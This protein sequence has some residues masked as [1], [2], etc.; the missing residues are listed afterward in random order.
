MPS[1]EV[2]CGDQGGNGKRVHVPSVLVVA[3]SLYEF[4]KAG[5]SKLLASNN[6]DPVAL[7]KT[8]PMYDEK[9]SDL[10]ERIRV[11]MKDQNHVAAEDALHVLK[12]SGNEHAYKS[13]YNTYVNGLGNQKQVEESTCSASFHTQASKYLVCSHT[14]LPVHKVY[15]DDNGHCRPLYRRGMENSSDGGAFLTTSKIYFQ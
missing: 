10:V 14:G 6:T 3:G 5:L 9:P 4:N 1:A 8:S 11:A 7:A 2:D 15:Q 12:Q 13:G